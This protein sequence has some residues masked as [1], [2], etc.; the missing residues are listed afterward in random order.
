MCLSMFLFIAV[1]SCRRVI[2]M[3]EKVFFFFYHWN[4][5]LLGHHRLLVVRTNRQHNEAGAQANGQNRQ[6][7]NKR[8]AR[9]DPSPAAH[10]SFFFSPVR[11]SEWQKL[12]NHSVRI[13]RFEFLL[14]LAQP[15]LRCGVFRPRC[16]WEALSICRLF[17]RFLATH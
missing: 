6:S 7:N 4:F 1:L 11:V 13:K 3:E 17:T 10:V 5:V 16:F 15:P 8:H 2:E 9:R 12:S 14:S